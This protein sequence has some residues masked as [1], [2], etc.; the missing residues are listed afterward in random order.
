MPTPRFFENGELL[1]KNEN[2]TVQPYVTETVHEVKS[3]S[4]FFQAI[5]AGAKVHDLR[6]NDRD[7]NV[8]DILLLREYD[9]INGRYTGESIEAVIT[10]IT[11]NRVP[12]AFSSAVLHE[13][14]CILSLK[15]LP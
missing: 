4:H 1:I 15:V 10:Y 2:P 13:G 5:K 9:F 12:C 7:Y 3:W 14:Y 6:K 11:D 8:G